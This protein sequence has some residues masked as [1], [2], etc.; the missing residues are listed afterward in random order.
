MLERLVITCCVMFILFAVERGKRTALEAQV[1][2]LREF[3]GD[4]VE[5]GKS[6][7]EYW[8]S[9]YDQQQ[10]LINDLTMKLAART[11]SERQ[12]LEPQEVRFIQPLT[13]D[14]LVALEER[15]RQENKELIYG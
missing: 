1:E 14:E 15:E 6:D 12:A 5:R 4:E 3:L 8:R 9:V 13:D 7:T 2:V 10:E 11:Y